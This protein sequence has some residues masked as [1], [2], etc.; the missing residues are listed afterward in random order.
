MVKRKKIALVNRVAPEY[1]IPF[2]RSLNKTLDTENLD[3]K[4]FYGSDSPENVS[5]DDIFLKKLYSLEFNS[6]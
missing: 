3:L 4:V 5:D 2:F 6:I 1:R